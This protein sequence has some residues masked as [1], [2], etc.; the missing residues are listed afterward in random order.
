MIYCKSSLEY[1]SGICSYLILLI[2]ARDNLL[3]CK[4]NSL[5]HEHDIDYVAKSYCPQV[6]GKKRCRHIL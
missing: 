3:A 4:E 2:G 5:L 1:I 6:V